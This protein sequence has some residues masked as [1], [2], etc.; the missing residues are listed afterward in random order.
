M[1]IYEFNSLSENEKQ[2]VLLSEGTEVSRKVEGDN[3][4]I[5]YQIDSFYVEGKYHLE[6][7]LKEC[8]SFSSTDLLG[9][10]LENID[11]TDL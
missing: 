8:K 4:F 10:Y 7:V 2:K 5:L 1:G 11:I 6:S 9:P 3:E